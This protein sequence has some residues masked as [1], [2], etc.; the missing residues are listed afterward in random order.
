MHSGFAATSTYAIK[1]CS[2]LLPTIDDQKTCS[3]LKTLQRLLD[4]KIKILSPAIDLVE[5]K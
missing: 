5:F 2:R 1:Q 3:E 4:G